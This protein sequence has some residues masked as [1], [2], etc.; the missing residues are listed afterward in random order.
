MSLNFKLNFLV[1]SMC[2]VASITVTNNVDDFRVLAIKILETATS[3]ISKIKL[4]SFAIANEFEPS[5]LV[6]YINALYS[7]RVYIIDGF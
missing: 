2:N 5:F 7:P 1:L 3:K 4:E 6:I